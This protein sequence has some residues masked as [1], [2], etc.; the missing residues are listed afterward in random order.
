MREKPKK[1]RN[2][3]IDKQ[4]LINSVDADL[5]PAGRWLLARNSKK[6][7]SE[8]RSATIREDLRIS[9]ADKVE[10]GLPGKILRI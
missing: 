9:D 2:L 5:S 8:C 10:I 4:R 3:N 6:S 1:I 7:L